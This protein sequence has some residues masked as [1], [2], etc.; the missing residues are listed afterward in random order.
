MVKHNKTE[1]E[2]PATISFRPS[3]E[4]WQQLGE[5]LTWYNDSDALNRKTNISDVLRHAIATLYEVMEEDTAEQKLL[6]D[7][8]K[9]ST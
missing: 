7:K 4:S 8:I 9:K 5:L 3:A 6:M 2:E 1:P